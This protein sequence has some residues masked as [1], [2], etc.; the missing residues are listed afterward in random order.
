MGELPRGR[1]E[2]GRLSEASFKTETSLQV[3]GT[4]P[5]MGK[6]AGGGEGAPHLTGSPCQYR[7]K[8]LV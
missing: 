3:A 6:G 8:R 1:D 2:E 7:D 5:L 4:L